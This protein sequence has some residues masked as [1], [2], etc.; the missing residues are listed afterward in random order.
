MV[1]K[2]SGQQKRARERCLCSLSRALNLES[3]VV[4]LFSKVPTSIMYWLPSADSNH[5]PD[6]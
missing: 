3:D 4:A 1:P 6:G 5:G 2:N